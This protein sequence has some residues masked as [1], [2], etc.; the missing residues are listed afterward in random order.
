MTII[1]ELLKVYINV[2]LLTRSYVIIW[3]LNYLLGSYSLQ[4]MFFVTEGTWP[5]TAQHQ[6]LSYDHKVYGLDIFWNYV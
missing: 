5:S 6:L 2:V 1:A 4:F 3:H